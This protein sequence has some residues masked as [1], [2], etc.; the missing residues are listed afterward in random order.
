MLYSAKYN[1]VFIRTPKAG[2]TT[3]STYLLDSGL[4][5]ANTDTYYTELNQEVYEDAYGNMTLE[6]LDPNSPNI[7]KVKNPKV[8]T[9]APHEGRNAIINRVSIEQVKRSFFIANPRATEEEYEAYR[10]SRK[11]KRDVIVRAF[12]VNNPGVT[13][14]LP[15]S[16][17]EIDG[18]TILPTI[19]K[20]VHATYSELVAQKVIPE[21][22][23]CFSTIR[24]PIERWVSMVNVVYSAEDIEQEGIDSLTSKLLTSMEQVNAEIKD[25]G[26]RA[27]I[28]YTLDNFL[29]DGLNQMMLTQQH[30][31]VSE[32]ATLWPTEHIHRLVPEFIVSKGG[33]VRADWIARVNDTKRTPPA[34][35]TETQQRLEAFYVKDLA[36]WELATSKFE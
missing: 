16:P 13:A 36:L 24:N 31:F 15:T 6:A 18:K 1:S 23:K 9:I 10:N 29:P 12:E 5:N 3:M 20:N 22:A 35:S 21:N 7:I 8:T 30:W 27:L 26:Q 19:T 33:R 11:G 17:D 2:S 34:F 28:A 14:E 25:G 4:F 32:D